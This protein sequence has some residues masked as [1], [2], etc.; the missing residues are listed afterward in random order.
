MHQ[1]QA[2]ADGLLASVKSE[3]FE[4]LGTAHV[5]GSI[6]KGLNPSQRTVIRIFRAWRAAALIPQ[7]KPQVVPRFCQSPWIFGGSDGVATSPLE[8]LAKPPQKPTARN[9]SSASSLLRP[10]QEGY[11]RH[12]PEGLQGPRTYVG[13]SF[14][15]PFVW[16][17]RL[18]E[19]QSFA[20]TCVVQCSWITNR[21]LTAQVWTVSPFFPL[22]TFS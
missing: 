6:R 16:C 21:S 20:F 2:R 9:R 8:T 7:S 15:F 11:Q 12:A 13:S 4:V 14:R 22:S 1:C 10:G 17:I 19:I 18:P 5:D 3:I